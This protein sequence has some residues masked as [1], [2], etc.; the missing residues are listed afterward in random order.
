MALVRTRIKQTRELRAL[1]AATLSKRAGLGPTAIRDIEQFD[2][3]D[4]RV[5][6]LVK[7][8]SV[9]ETTVD[10]LVNEPVYLVGKVGAGGAILYEASDDPVEV[11]RPPTTGGTLIALEVVGDSMF[12][13]YEDGD[14]VYVRREHEGV[15]PDY[16]G[17]HCVVHTADGGT[18]LKILTAGGTPGT[19]TLRSHNAA[20][21]TDVEVLWATPVLWAMPRR[22]RS[23]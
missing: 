11:R 5:S 3:E 22:S 17:E 21:M 9:L 14:I 8:A 4:I 2:P 19:F 10:S 6:T 16:L 20:D 1:K 23:L 15:L 13:K 12:P 7:I 18:F